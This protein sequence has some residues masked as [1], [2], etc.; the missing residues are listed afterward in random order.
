MVQSEQCDGR[1]GA[2]EAQAD[3]EETEGERL[4]NYSHVSTNISL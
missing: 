4:C 1:R 2:T 3:L